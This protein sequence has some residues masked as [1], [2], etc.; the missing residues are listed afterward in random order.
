MKSRKLS[1]LFITLFIA[2]ILS[3]TAFAAETDGIFTYTVSG[4]N[5][6]ITKIAW[7]GLEEITIPEEIGGYTITSIG[8]AVMTDTTYHF[9][10]NCVVDVVIPK[11]V[12]KIDTRAFELADI[13]HFVV[14]E[15]NPNYSSDEYGVLFNKDKSI[16]VRAA[17]SFD[18][19]SYTVPD[20]V[21]EIGSQAFHS[22]LF[23]QEV[24]IPDTVTR[25]REQ[26][27]FQALSL[28]NVR[29]PEGITVLDQNLFAR[30]SS[31]EKLVVPSTVTTI[32]NSCVT[33]CTALKKV[34][35]SEGV[36]AI[37]NYA[38]ESDTALEYVFLPS[39]IQNIGPGAFGNCTSLKDICYAGTQE[40]WA[41][42]SV[43]TGAYYGDRMNPMDTVTVHS[44]ISADAYLAI[45]F[46]DDD[47]LL[48]IT[49]AGAMPSANAGAWHYWDE[50]KDNVT[51]IIIDGDID[52]IGA[53]S[54][55]SYPALTT[56]IVR[57]PGINIEPMAFVN[58]PLLETV[59][60]F[61]DSYFES[62]SFT[63]CAGE[64]RVFEDAGANHNFNLSSTSINVIKFSFDG[65]VLA[66][67]GNLSLDAYEFFDTMAVF[68][69]QFE[70]IEKIT[71]TR[72]AFENITMFY[73]PGEGPER[74]KVEGNTLTN[75]EIYPIIFEN[76]DD[77]PI[78][79][80]RLCEGI[81][82]KSI[83]NFTLIAKDDTHHEIVDTEI[84]VKEEESFIV[85]ALRWVVTLLNKLF[86]LISKLK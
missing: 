68:S 70:N 63:G 72:F 60:I 45:D 34:I 44:D 55:E 64:I 81:A 20:S 27:F 33:E 83:T 31:L 73:Y 66:F 16:L 79:F 77:T 11:T 39:T 24:I 29:L 8:S 61:P 38:F 36:T 2:A 82:D 78:T 69:L 58:C 47:G 18:S 50:N 48:T 46:S 35:I 5:A 17:T 86:S 4:S 6:T 59:I 41:Q 28:K 42:V 22:S 14:S 51:A 12:T 74:L 71:F 84:E 40:E 56:L 30:C 13:N 53:H 3:F 80:N 10:D 9:G 19:L 32:K 65:A 23:I 76:G 62:A 37:D 43:S 26:A 75:G 52:R 49:G 25:I 67:D 54:F 85:K 57:T 21:T 7:E 15:E 1:Y